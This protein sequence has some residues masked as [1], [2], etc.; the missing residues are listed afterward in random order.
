MKIKISKRATHA[1]NELMLLQNV[2]ARMWQNVVVF[3]SVVNCQDFLIV[4][5]VCSRRRPFQDWTERPAAAVA[6]SNWLTL[7]TAIV[8][9]VCSVCALEEPPSH[10]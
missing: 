8:G 6:G 10:F 4:G 3:S 1:R 7:D 2:P 5:S 9:L